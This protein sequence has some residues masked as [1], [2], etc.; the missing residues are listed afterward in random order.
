MNKAE[1]LVLLESNKYYLTSQ[2]Y[3]GLRKFVSN[4]FDDIWDIEF[5]DLRAQ[6]YDEVWIVLYGHSLEFRF[7]IDNKESGFELFGENEK[8]IFSFNTNLYP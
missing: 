7:W 5:E 2:T 1:A 4:I 8:N 3:S 6:R